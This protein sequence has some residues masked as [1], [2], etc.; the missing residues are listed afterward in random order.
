MNDGSSV[1]LT[2]PGPGDLGRRDAVEVGGVDDRLGDL[3]GVAAERLGQRQRAVGLGVGAV[4]RPH[5]RVD[6][7][8]AGDGVERRLQPGGEDVERIGHGTAHCAASARSR[9][10]GESASPRQAQRVTRGGRRR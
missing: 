6:A 4:G 1:R 10:I 3:A 7:G 2:K 5:D 8:A 9:R